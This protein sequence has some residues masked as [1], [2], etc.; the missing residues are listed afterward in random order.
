MQIWMIMKVWV[1]KLLLCG[2]ISLLSQSAWAFKHTPEDSIKLKTIGESKYVIHKVE[3]GETLGS[4]ANRYGSEVASILKFNPHIKDEDVIPENNI[5]SV[6][7]GPNRLLSDGFFDNQVT[8]ADQKTASQSGKPIQHKVVKGDNLFQLSQ[9]Y[10]VT[11]D[12]IKQWNNLPDDVVKIDQ[13][14]TVGF[15]PADKVQNT[16]TASAN[17]Q[18][19]VYTSGNAET[20]ATTYHTVAKGETSTKI[21]A[22]YGMSV[23]DLAAL[24]K[25]DDPNKINLGQ[26]LLVV[27]NKQNAAQDSK[28]ESYLTH[29]VKAKETLTKIGELYGVTKAQILDWNKDNIPDPDKIKVGDKVLIATQAVDRNSDGFKKYKAGNAEGSYEDF[30]A[31]RIY[32]TQYGDT[33]DKIAKQFGIPVNTLISANKDSVPNP[34]LL[35]IGTNLVVP[36]SAALAQAEARKLEATQKQQDKNLKANNTGSGNEEVTKQPEIKPGIYVVQMGDLAGKIAEKYNIGLDELATWNGK[37]IQELNTLKIGDKLMI[38]KVNTKPPKKKTPSNPLLMM[39]NGEIMYKADKK[40]DDLHNFGDKLVDDQT[41]KMQQLQQQ[42]VKG[43]SGTGT[44]NNQTQTQ[45]QTNTNNQ[46]VETFRGSTD[47]NKTSTN[48]TEQKTQAVDT[49]KTTYDY[50]KT[51]TNNTETNT[52]AANTNANTQKNVKEVEMTG[53]GAIAA[54]DVIKNHKNAIIQAKTIPFKQSVWV[55]NTANNVRFKASV[56]EPRLDAGDACEIRMSQTLF[57]QINPGGDKNATL[58]IKVIYTQK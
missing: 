35:K 33:F 14:L 48:N 52:N 23:K 17:N 38:V 28:E 6:P 31:Y 15:S 3:S 47:A 8:A 16:L 12:Q 24:N 45:T 13:L 43:L 22:Q 58:N 53:L 34:S 51:Q 11:K 2:L 46:V 56:V 57:N 49:L 7:I 26:K 10:K 30:V 40:D 55:V 20:K 50:A 4:I 36:D 9:K 32:K 25:L 5:I 42:S 54:D 39:K 21:A 19:K 29:T 18:E 1:N 37:T 41:K 44:N 27:A